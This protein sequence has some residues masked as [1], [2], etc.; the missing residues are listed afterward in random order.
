MVWCPCIQVLN[1]AR[2]RPSPNDW[3]Q[4]QEP[5]QSVLADLEPDLIL[6]TG[7]DLFHHATKIP[8]VQPH[9]NRPGLL[10]PIRKNAFAYARCIYHPSSI[11]FLR[12]K[13]HCAEIVDELIGRSPI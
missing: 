4:A 13:E 6:L 10:L 2:L 8:N 11:K 1:R 7:T 3:E 5:F 12:K 9:Q